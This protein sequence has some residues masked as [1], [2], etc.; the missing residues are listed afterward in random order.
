MT[1]LCVYTFQEA[2]IARNLCSKTS[3]GAINF[4]LY[5]YLQKKGEREREIETEREEREE[6]REGTNQFFWRKHELLFLMF[7]L[8]TVGLSSLFP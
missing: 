7:L 1:V 6:E 5:A 2:G 8:R 4:I 3:L